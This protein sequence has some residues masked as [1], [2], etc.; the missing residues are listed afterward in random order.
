M[1]N[2][3]FRTKALRG[4]PKSGVDRAAKRVNGVKVMQMGKVNDSRPWEVD[5]ETL[6]QVVQFGNAPNK[7]TKA[8]FTHPSMSDDGFGKY[9]GRWTNFRVEGDS[10]YADL[11]LA[12]SAF[13]TPNGDLG[14]YILDMAEE[15]P[16]SFGVSAATSLAGVMYTEVP[17]GKTLPL[18]LDG[19]RAVDFVDEPA[20]TRGGL[21]DMESPAG[22]PA[23]ATWIVETH[24]SDREP[25]EVL[26][27]LSSFLSKHYGREIVMS[28]TAD[29]ADQGQNPAPAPV[30]PAGLSLDG[31]KPWIEAFGQ[32]GAVWYIEGRSMADCFG[33][34]STELREANE[35]LQA[36][37][38]DLQTRLDAAL[39]AASGESDALSS[40][41]KTEIP[42]EKQAKLKRAEELKAQGVGE[43]TAK[44]AAAFSG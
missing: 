21:F 37:V 20:A 27:R 6:D 14:T 43:K 23:L 35:A 1:Q 28:G 10:A 4:A 12:E 40:T 30:A 24:F 7:G 2:N 41:P 5:A 39:K 11:Q 31:A 9:L 32:R 22:L 18:R 17:E 13:N 44:W 16:E 38:T 36:Q 33:V 26:Q 8:R 19:L 34:L 25:E 42:E 15:D 29:K 3:L